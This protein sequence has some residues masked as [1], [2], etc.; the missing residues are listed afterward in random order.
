MLT[1]GE[2]MAKY[3]VGIDLGTSSVRAFLIDFE[4]KQSWIE[5]EN[6]DVLIPQL[7]YAEQDPQMWYSKMCNVLRGVLAKSG[8][9]PEDIVA[10]SFSGQMHGLV[11]L[12]KG[13][14]SV[15]NVPI[16]MDQRS[17]EAI[18][19][20][21][22]ALG[23]D[24]VRENTQNHIATGF[25][26][27]SLYWYKT[28]REEVYKR[29]A[30]VMLPKDYIKFRLSGRITTDYSDASGSLVFDNVNL[31][32]AKP[33]LQGLGIREE[34]FPE[35]LPSTAVIGHVCAEAAR[36]T[37]LSEKTLV[38]N[39]GA[40]QCMQ[41]IGNAVVDEG[42]FATNIGTSSLTTTPSR[43]PYYDTQLR[44]HTFAHAI[45]GHWTIMAA[46]LNGGSVLK[47]LNNRILQVSGYEEINRMV[48]TRESGSGG[49]FFLPYMDGERTP[50]MDSKARGM[51]FGLTMDH[52]REDMARAV[53]EG[54]VFAM[55]SGM[56]V[57]EDMGVRCER[58]IAAGGG[59][60][61]DVWLQ[62]QADIF[63]HE[64]C[65]SASKE[66]ACMGAA[67]TAAIGAGTFDNYHDACARCVEPSTQIFVP[68]VEN[69]RVYRRMYPVF[70]D[71]YASNRKLF[72]DVSDIFRVE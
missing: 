31:C 14:H 55:K 6:Y 50:H 15:M 11:A 69:V 43:K 45:P 25:L 54:I 71:L 51:F 52:G 30:H 57:L 62:M 38:V 13:L 28:R 20:I 33:I 48:A 70:K 9:N 34:I 42:V 16:W 39:G 7:G 41:S 18:E 23:R 63:E 22:A 56:D 61:S 58:I 65:R 35:C 37:G 8:A 1:Q 27:P 21:Y 59:A 19:E 10:L 5:G 66:Q 40:D 2:T 53:M 4:R 29:I 24:L 72:A 67:I 49:L 36:D 32:W 17:S 46:H 64:V 12:D 26:L 68:K 47:W 3:F 44:T 60:R